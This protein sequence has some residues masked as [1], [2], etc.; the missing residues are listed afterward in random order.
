[1]DGH[2]RQREQSARMIETALFELMKERDFAEITVT[3]IV[4]RADVARRTFYRLYS[5]KEA[6]IDSYIDRMCREYCSTYPK[7]GEYDLSQIAEDYFTFWYQY[8][9][10]LMLMNRSGLCGKLYYRIRC[11]SENVVRNRIGDADIKGRSEVSFFALYSAG[12]FLALLQH[13]V[14]EGMKEKPGQYAQKVSKALLLF[15]NPVIE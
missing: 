5:G 3:E 14:T 1:M 8:R 7:L 12:G 6:V 13:W 10:F 11:E 4:K 9:E 15:I 2:K